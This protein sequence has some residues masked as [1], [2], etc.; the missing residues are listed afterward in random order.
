M[1]QCDIVD[2][3]IWMCFSSDIVEIQNSGQK[4]TCEQNDCNI[5]IG[6]YCDEHTTNKKFWCKQHKH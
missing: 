1:V 3:D 2:C 4:I 5:V 6:N